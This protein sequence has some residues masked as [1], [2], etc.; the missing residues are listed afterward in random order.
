VE[1]VLLSRVCSAIETQFFRLCIVQLHVARRCPSFN[2][3]QL[4]WT[5]MSVS[6]WDD[7]VS[8]ISMLQDLISIMDRTQV[9]CIILFLL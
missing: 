5:R 8:I 1:A 9:S 3:Y 6:C 7:Q 4:L 2:M